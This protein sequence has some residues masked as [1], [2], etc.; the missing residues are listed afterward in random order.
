MEYMYENDGRRIVV[1]LWPIPFASVLALGRHRVARWLKNSCLKTVNQAF[2]CSKNW[3]NIYDKYKDIRECQLRI[4]LQMSFENGRN[5]LVGLD[6]DSRNAQFFDQHTRA[7][8][9]HPHLGPKAQLNTTNVTFN[10]IR[11]TKA[12]FKQNQ[13]HN[14]KFEVTD[15]KIKSINEDTHEIKM[16]NWGP[17]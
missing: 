7:H 2:D 6:V 5:V 11:F 15:E 12:D 17:V 4:G 13:Y 9:V 8:Q 16:T 10:W 3:E 1:S 14:I